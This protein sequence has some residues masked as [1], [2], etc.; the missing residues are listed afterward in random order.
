MG[1]G[2]ILRL[3]KQKKSS[4]TCKEIAELINQGIRSTRAN[5]RKLVKN[6]NVNRVKERNK[7]KYKIMREAIIC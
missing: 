6:G 4:L 7:I 3:L 2:E 1:Q 5:L